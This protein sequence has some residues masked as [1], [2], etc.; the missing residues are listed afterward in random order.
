MLEYIR[1]A[2]LDAFWAREGSTA[3]TKLVGNA[4]TERTMDRLKLPDAKPAIGPF[5]LEESFGIQAAISVLDRSSDPGE[6]KEMVQWD[7]FR[8]FRAAIANTTQAG[9]HGLY[10]VIGAY[11]HKRVWITNA[12]TY[13]MWLLE[14]FMKGTHKRHSSVVKQDWPIPIQVLHKVDELLERDWS[15]ATGEIECKTI[16]VLGAWYIKGFCSGLRGEEML[17]LKYNG[18]AKGL[19]FHNATPTPYYLLVLSGKTKDNQVSGA[20]LALP[21]AAG[22][23]GTNIQPD[24]WSKRLVNC[25]KAE[26][27]RGGRLF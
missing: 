27:R 20:K 9:V 6:Y 11:E 24:K 12:P 22:M 16:V 21:V 4:R 17:L 19:R 25:I 7:T 2:N 26:C 18:T 8:H 5:P 14:R 13:T 1:R 10:D 23:E 15:V 3:G